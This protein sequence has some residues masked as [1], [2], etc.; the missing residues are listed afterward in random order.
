MNRLGKL[1]IVIVAMASA[2]IA[3]A[4]PILSAG[5]P[6]LDGAS[7]WDFNELTFDAN[8]QT[9]Y[10]TSP[11]EEVVF[12]PDGVTSYAIRDDIS[13][14]DGMGI[15]AFGNQ[16]TATYNFVFSSLVSAFGLDL[17]SINSVWTATAYDSSNNLIESVAW[18][19]A[20]NQS[21]LIFRGVAADGIAWISLSGN[22][23]LVIDN[24][25]YVTTGVA[26]PNFTI[27]SDPEP[28]PVPE[29][30]TLALFGIGLFGMGLA[31]RRKRLT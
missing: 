6:A 22:D 12:G 24:L 19:N 26:N 21:S 9:G 13:S 11:T 1:I 29:P 20:N 10:I 2:A 16:N 4:T 3:Q 30:S 18:P 23:D 7:L 17:G 5:D 14:S 28:T 31:R 25:N 8:R 15:L 27:P